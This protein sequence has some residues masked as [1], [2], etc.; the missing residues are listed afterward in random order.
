M[1][2]DS[3]WAILILIVPG[4]WLEQALTDGLIRKSET[5]TIIRAL[6][7]GLFF[8]WI[9]TGLV[10][11]AYP[12]GASEI[13]RALFSQPPVSSDGFLALYS[14]AVLAVSFLIYLLA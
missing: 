9:I 2:V 8:N 10:A 14:G 7:Y 3:L 12:V 13:L 5:A 1:S 4:Y 11:L 6:T